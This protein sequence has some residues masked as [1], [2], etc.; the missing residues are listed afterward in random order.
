MLLQFDPTTHGLKGTRYNFLV[1]LQLRYR[2]NKGPEVRHTAAA[3]SRRSITSLAVG[4]TQELVLRLNAHIQ[5]TL[6]SS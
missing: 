5:V 1:K 6:T 2:T 4:C 3:N